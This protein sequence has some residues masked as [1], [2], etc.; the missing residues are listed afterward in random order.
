MKHLLM[1]IM[2]QYLFI[3][4]YCIKGDEKGGRLGKMAI[5]IPC[6]HLSCHLEEL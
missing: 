6:I 2:Y 5:S 3:A 1:I 4:L